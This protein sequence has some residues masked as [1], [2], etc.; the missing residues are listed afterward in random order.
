M[1]KLTAILIICCLWLSGSLL[2]A[3]ISGATAWEVRP[4]VGSD[5]SGGCFVTGATGT[6]FSQQN[7]AQYNFTDLVIDGAT[8]TIVTSASH[9]FVAADVGNCMNITAG[10]GFTQGIY[11]VVSVSM[12]AATMD[13]NVGTLASTGGTFAVGG[14]VLTITK[15][16]A[17]AVNSNRIFVKASAAITSTVTYSL[18]G[19]LQPTSATPYNIIQGYTTTRTDNG[20]VTITLST[21]TG[22]TALSTAAGWIVRNFDIN[23]ATLGTSKAVSIGNFGIVQNVKASNCTERGIFANS[24]VVTVMDSEITGC[25][26]ACDASLYLVGTGTALRNWIHDNA[27]YGVRA[28]GESPQV[29]WNLITNN[30]GATTAG[31]FITSGNPVRA[32]VFGNTVYASGQDGIQFSSTEPLGQSNVRNNILV[33]NGRYG[34]NGASAAGL[35]AQPMFDGNFYFGNVTAA[36]NNMNDAGSVNAINAAAPYTNVLD[37]NLSGDPFTNAATNDFSLNAIA[38]AGLA[39]RAAGTPG[40]IPGVA[41][42]GF[43]DGGVFQHQD[44]GGSGGMKVSAVAK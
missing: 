30:T 40:A 12:N 5:N 1:K 43:I 36:R 10:T 3:A 42:L 16:A 25:T 22:L 23:C 33:N 15:A 41:T 44:S 11:Q 17:S 9:N 8:A 26:S 28:N 35:S 31:I 2:S 20:R 39:V 18:T 32:V 38:G 7:A 27:S 4:G 13:R 14:A 19:N 21:N 34:V 6:D 24:N 29:I 37:V